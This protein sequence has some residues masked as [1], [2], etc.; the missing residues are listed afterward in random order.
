MII[1]GNLTKYWGGGVSVVI[2]NP[3]YLSYSGRQAVKL[4]DNIREYYLR[5][6]DTAGWL[7][8][9]G[10]FILKALDIAK[11]MVGFIVPDQ[12]GHLD[13][14][15]SIR[16][17]VM[18]KSSLVNVRYWGESVFADA[19]TP[20]L[21]FITDTKHKGPTKFIAK[22]R[23]VSKHKIQG[24]EYW[25]PRTKYFDLIEKIN[26]QSSP[27]PDCFADPGI[28]TGNCSKKLIHGEI[29]APKGAVP[30][31]EGKQI[32]RYFCDVPK[33]VVDL[34]YV[35]SKGE[36]FNI[37]PIEIYQRS[38]FVI[39]QTAPY[40]ICGPKKHADYFRNSLLALF[41]PTDGRDVRYIVALLNSQLLRFAYE[42]TVR[43][44]DQKAF[45][46]V[47]VR[48]LRSLPLRGIDFT[49]KAEKEHHDNIVKLVE[50][51]MNL[52]EKID[53]ATI[54]HQV[55][56]LQRRIESIDQ[57][58]NSLVEKLYGL[59]QEERHQVQ[60]YFEESSSTNME[61]QSMT[62]LKVCG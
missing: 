27:L 20:S 11:R 15:E 29:D 21:T 7:T 2:G 17:A 60:K 58:I 42:T 47:K 35:P 23:E 34:Y 10:L 57:D 59:T 22:D 50:T 3:P 48:S 49:K 24:A 8:S 5:K 62:E 18:K 25:Q 55:N 9:H 30:V 40:P 53:K 16:K 4:D 41:P 52:H 45:P 28:H 32:S 14:Y 39:R 46:Q 51:L 19:V 38:S 44:S 26:Q 61:Q 36:Y 37:R 56:V 43:E 13:G 1:H 54:P 12:V 6:Y 33:K 31:L